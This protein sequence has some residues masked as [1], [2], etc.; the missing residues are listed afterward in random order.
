M[1][2]KYL[3]V[4]LPEEPMLSI[5]Q[6]AKEQTSAALGSKYA[7]ALPIH[8]TVLPPF[9]TLEYGEFS[10]ELRSACRK[11]SSFTVR[12]PSYS[13]FEDHK[14]LKLDLESP[15]LH[16]LHDMAVE[17]MAKYKQPWKREEKDAFATSDRDKELLE[18]YGSQYV[19]ENY[20][21]HMTLA[22]PDVN[23]WYLRY[24]PPLSLPLEF[25]VAKLSIFSK[26]KELWNLQEQ[27]PLRQL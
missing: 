6:N 4:I 15:E 17:L 23:E 5:L 12:V 22:G 24:E 13:R 20:S 21:P 9:K 7:L 25:T 18:R 8:S 19:K 14:V 27:M 1:D 2:K 11:F 3:A 16:N 26:E 10:K